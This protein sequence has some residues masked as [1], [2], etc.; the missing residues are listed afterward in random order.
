MSLIVLK[1]FNYPISI[2]VAVTKCTQIKHEDND[3][4]FLI[5]LTTNVTSWDIEHTL[6]EFEELDLMLRQSQ[7][8]ESIKLPRSIAQLPNSRFGESGKQI[9]EEYLWK[10][11]RRAYVFISSVVQS[12]IESPIILEQKTIILRQQLRTVLREDSIS[13]SAENNN[14]YVDIGCTLLCS[15]VMNGYAIP[16]N[17]LKEGQDILFHIDCVCIK[18]VIRY[19]K[20]HKFAIEIRGG[21]IHAF[22]CQNEAQFNLWINDIKNM[23]KAQGG[24][25]PYLVRWDEEKMD[26]LQ[27]MDHLEAAMAIDDESLDYF[28]D[29]WF[30]HG[31][32][33]TMDSLTKVAPYSPEKEAEDMVDRV[34]I[35]IESCL[36]HNSWSKE[37]AIEHEE[38]EEEDHV[39][40]TDSMITLKLQKET[41]VKQRRKAMIASQKERMLHNKRDRMALCA[42]KTSLIEYNK[43]NTA[44]RRSDEHERMVRMEEYNALKEELL[45]WQSKA[46]RW[47]DMA[48]RHERNHEHIELKLQQKEV[49][50]RAK[51]KDQQNEILTL[52]KIIK[53]SQM[54]LEDQR[55][56][57]RQLESASNITIQQLIAYRNT[58]EMRKKN[59]YIDGTLWKF[60]GDAMNNIKFNKAPRLKYVMY[61]PTKR[62]LYYSDSQNDDADT[63]LI[64]VT[65][66]SHKNHDAIGHLPDK[67]RD[68][69][70]KI[71]G[72]NRIVLFVA[73][74][75]KDAERW[76][77]TIKNSLQNV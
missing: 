27:D 19:Q 75:Q 61:V 56:E 34:D 68:I 63:K 40:D 44:N 50:Y 14:K 57:L 7:E 22:K 12:F 74:N 69:W 2:N 77:Q 33:S 11:L 21:F 64:N 39:D 46:N 60:T 3:W 55:F 70:I 30:E 36:D 59:S 25:T 9:I 20:E 62:R 1:A 10:L 65:F 24:Y 51:I 23:I 49:K 72:Q 38:E 73:K 29:D 76:Y 52:T 35:D 8:L 43:P 45:K 18:R 54:E 15:Y 58:N 26:H 6:S 41:L 71:I 17:E 5:R 47:Q 31:P 42:E 53:Q 13:Y 37:H 67:Y 48:N 66:I 16:N 4:S 28:D 32:L